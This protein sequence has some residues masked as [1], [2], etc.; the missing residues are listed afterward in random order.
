MNYEISA[1]REC[2]WNNFPG[3]SA[4]RRAL[5]CHSCRYRLP[6]WGT[7][8]RINFHLSTQFKGFSGIPLRWSNK[9]RTLFMTSFPC[10]NDA[11]ASENL[12]DFYDSRWRRKHHKH[13][14]LLNSQP[15]VRELIL[16]SVMVSFAADKRP[17]RA[18]Q[19]P[20]RRGYR[21]DRS[22]WRSESL[23]FDP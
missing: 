20:H 18:E 16:S 22:C 12:N 6:R 21:F 15:A 17:P 19:A 13:R 1:R 3:R 2:W 4:R 7:R 11:V 14:N 9:T 5:I 10:C 23:I 8:R